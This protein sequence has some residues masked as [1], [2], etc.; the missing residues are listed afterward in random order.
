MFHIDKGGDEVAT[1]GSFDYANYGPSEISSTGHSRHSHSSLSSKTTGLQTLESK[2]SSLQSFHLEPLPDPPP[3]Q[4]RATPRVAVVQKKD[5]RATKRLE[6]ERLELEKRLLKL[7]EAERTGDTSV[8]RRESRK[9]SKKQPLGSSSRS[10]SVSGDESR[11]RPPSRLSSIFSSS[12]R[13]SRSRC[14][15]NDGAEDQFSSNGEPSTLPALSSTLPERLSTAISEEL[16]ARKNATLGPPRE[17]PQS[18]VTATIAPKNPEQNGEEGAA[19]SISSSAPADLDRELFTASLAS[20]RRS[21]MPSSP[22]HVS[23]AHQDS[24]PVVCDDRSRS[25]TLRVRSPLARA[26][27]EGVVQRHQKKFKSSPLAESH[28]ATTSSPR[29]VTLTSPQVPDTVRPQTLP[30]AEQA[31][32][33]EISAIGSPNALPSSNASSHNV[34]GELSV[35]ETRNARRVIQGGAKPTSQLAP[36]ALLM[37]P[38]FYNSLNKVIGPSGGKPKA[39]GTLSPPRRERDS[40]PTVPP[41]SPKRNSRALSR[42]PDLKLD[43]RPPPSQSKD[44]NSESDYNTADEIASIRSRV[45]DGEVVTAKS[46]GESKKAPKKRNLGQLVPKLFVICCQ[47]KFWHDMPSEVYAGL[48]VSDPLSA[49][50]DQ[51]LATWDQ[52]SLANRLLPSMNAPKFQHAD[53]QSGPVKCCWCEHPMSKGCCQGWSTLVQ[54]RKRHH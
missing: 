5:R 14:S 16:A 1:G 19:E 21:A 37:K 20:K 45:S 38:R 39:I 34:I 7:E 46:K 18:L 4:D 25:T 50:L 12:R 40:S 31:T 26:S 3:K 47:C 24:I 28:S 29:A 9:L 36:S 33:S 22:G 54:M 2:H 15:S 27:T 10:S 17:S 49:A 6:A 11:S 30:V 13:R 8:L 43:G 35:M 44:E 42:S 48:A 41:K 51:E 53:I 23:R 32:R 52:N